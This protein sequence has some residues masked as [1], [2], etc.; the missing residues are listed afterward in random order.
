MEKLW[1]VDITEAGT[2]KAGQAVKVQAIN[3]NTAINGHIDSVGVVPLSASEITAELNS[4]YLAQ[5]LLPR[6]LR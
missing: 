2:I 3:Q 6:A 4:D 1:F 5:A